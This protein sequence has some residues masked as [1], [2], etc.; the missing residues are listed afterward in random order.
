MLKRVILNIILT[1]GGV[2]IFIHFRYIV[3]YQRYFT[4]FMKNLITELLIL[5]V[6]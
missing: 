4:G 1:G 6:L 3:K 2:S 5:T